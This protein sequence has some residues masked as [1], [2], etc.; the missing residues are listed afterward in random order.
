MGLISMVILARKLTPYDF[1]LVSITEVVLILIS[2]LGTTGINEFLLAYKKKDFKEISKST[3]WLILV[4]SIG[5]GTLVMIAAP[6]WAESNGDERI[7]QLAAVLFGLFLC[8][9]FQIIPKTIFSRNLQFKTLVLYQTP[10]IILIPLLKIG[11]ALAGFGVFSLVLPPLLLRPIETLIL[12]RKAKFSPGMNMLR[13][14][15]GEIINFTKNLIGSTLLS[16][17]STEGDK[18]ILGKFIGLEALGIYNLAYQFSNFITSN[19]MTVGNNILSS[20]LPHYAE[21]IPLMRKHY[22]WYLKTIAFFLFPV[23]TIMAIGAEPLFSIVYGPKWV[24]AIL[25]FQILILYAIIRTVTTSFGSIMNTLH[26]PQVGFKVTLWYTPCHL[27]A[28]IIGAQF[29]IVGLAV[30]VVVVKYVFVMVGLVYETRALQTSVMAYFDNIGTTIFLVFLAALS[31][32]LVLFISTH[33][34]T[35]DSWVHLTSIVI[36]YCISYYLLSRLVAKRQ[37]ISISGF[38]NS[39][40]PRFGVYFDKLYNIKQVQE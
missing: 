38:L 24:D 11:A 23:L 37:N 8:S 7:T 4:L 33:W 15:W 35:Q 17:L 26:L 21:D 39:T 30:A 36:I 14:R 27:A 2:S 40:M 29:G 32:V 31:T 13:H 3:F 20:V 6:F 1:G 28:S 9:Q 34:I 22:F 18:L 10:F 12:Y 25:P 16:R 19:L 5:V